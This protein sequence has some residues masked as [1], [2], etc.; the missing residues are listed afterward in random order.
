M[1]KDITLKV[2]AF[3]AGTDDKYCIT[4]IKEI[5]FTLR[6]ISG[7]RKP[8]ALYFGA[9]NEFILTAMLNVENDGVWLEQSP[10]DEVNKKIAASD[11]LIVVGSHFSVKIQFSSGKPVLQEH[12]GHK[13]FFLALPDKLFRLQRR[14]YFRLT[15]PAVDP[16]KCV[17]TPKSQ[18]DKPHREVTI[19]DISGGG[20][21]L[22]CEENDTELSPGETHPDCR[23]DLP[24]FGTIIGTIVVK[25]IAV[26]TNAEGKNFK[27]AGCEI[28]NLDNP[29]K[30]ML[31]RY[32]LH[33]QRNKE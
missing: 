1:D 13:A 33:L 30:V 11:N 26:L 5:V 21:A 31:H 22:T 2:K 18:A 23:I 10:D 14:E 15:T 27:R 12:A 7:R 16:L 32:V 6:E 28:L 29:S 4:S 24:E 8:V 25:N 9:A 3:S 17:I 19:M 20:I